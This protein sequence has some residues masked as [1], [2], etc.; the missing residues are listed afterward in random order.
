MSMGAAAAIASRPG[1]P[2]ANDTADAL[3]TYPLMQEIGQPVDHAPE[4]AR[5]GGA[6]LHRPPRAPCSWDRRNTP[7]FTRALGMAREARST[8]RHAHSRNRRGI[9]GLL[10]RHGKLLEDLPR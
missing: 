1:G 5:P 9:R 10:H 2:A 3:I 4:H 6:A 8:L 7:R